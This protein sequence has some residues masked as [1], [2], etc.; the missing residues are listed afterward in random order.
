M[1]HN[2]KI[3]QFGAIIFTMSILVAGSASAQNIKRS[4][5]G[6]S[7]EIRYGTVETID[8]VKIQSQAGQGAVMGGLVGGA[9]SGH[10]HRGKHA[11]EGA[12][13]GALLTAILE[14][15]RKAYQYTVDFPDGTVTKVITESGG[16]VEG[17]C[18]VVEL[19]QTAN[20]RRTSSVHC[21]HGDHEALT[22][23][24]MVYAKRQTEA[25]EC[26]AAKDMALQA[27]TEEAIDIAIKKVRVFCEG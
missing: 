19:G 24:P 25:A 12:L 27:S 14:G 18:V 21:E 6:S 26:H 7:F 2:K 4:Q 13:A 1:I 22:D 10:H 20:I 5:L 11:V 3:A 23:A 9:T 15:N 8:R 17:D 16:I